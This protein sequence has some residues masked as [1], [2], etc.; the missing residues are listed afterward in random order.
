[1]ELYWQ[2]KMEMSHKITSRKCGRECQLVAIDGER[3]KKS[4]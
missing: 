1:M 4:G 3:E 2:T